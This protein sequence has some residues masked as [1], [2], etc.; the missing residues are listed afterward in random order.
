[1]PDLKMQI[2]LV[3]FLVRFWLLADARVGKLPV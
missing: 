1:L 3:M 2:G